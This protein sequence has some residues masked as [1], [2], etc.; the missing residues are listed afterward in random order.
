MAVKSTQRAFACLKANPADLSPSSHT[1]G[2]SPARESD[3]A[4]DRS[5]K[6]PGSEN[7][8]LAHKTLIEQYLLELPERQREQML[9]LPSE[10]FLP[11]YEREIEDYFRR[12]SAG[13]SEEEPR[14]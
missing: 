14:R 5:P 9:E 10:Y 11:E 4:V 13:K 12:L 2:K 6:Q 8:G 1:P 7:K 3:T